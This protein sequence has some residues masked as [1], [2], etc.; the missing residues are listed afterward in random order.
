MNPLSRWFGFRQNLW[1][2]KGSTFYRNTRA[3]RGFLKVFPSREHPSDDPIIQVRDVKLAFRGSHFFSQNRLLP[4]TW[5]YQSIYSRYHGI[6]TSWLHT[7]WHRGLLRGCWNN[8][9]QVLKTHRK[10]VGPSRIC[11]SYAVSER[12]T[13]RRMMF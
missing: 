4:E 11:F 13:E 2:T 10:A 1:K 5:K 3:T 7:F 8:N 6:F 9:W 12:R